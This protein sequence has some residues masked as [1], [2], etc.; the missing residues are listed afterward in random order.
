[1]E[2]HKCAARSPKG[3]AKQRTK[4]IGKNKKTDNFKGYKQHCS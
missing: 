1:M 4:K 2:D 3:K